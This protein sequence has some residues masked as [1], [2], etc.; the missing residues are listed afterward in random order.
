[1][2]ATSGKGLVWATAA[3]EITVLARKVRREGE[4]TL[5]RVTGCELSLKI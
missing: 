1:M 4:N 3:P 2:T 5:L